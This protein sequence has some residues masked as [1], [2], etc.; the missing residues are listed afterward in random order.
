M[1]KFRV[2]IIGCGRPW[3]DAGRSGCGQAHMH[4]LGYKESKDCEIVAAADIK[5]ENLD[6]FTAEYTIPK[7]YLDYHEMFAKEKIDIVSLCVWPKLHGPMTFDSVDAGVKAIH[8]E[9]PIAP[10]FGEAKEM[11]ECCAKK[12]VQLTFNHQRRF[13]KPFRKAKELIET[14]AI[15]KLERIEMYTHNLYDWGTHWFDMMFYYNN[16]EPVEW[17]MGQVDGRGSMKIFDA[18]VEGQGLSYLKFKNAVFGFM[19]TGFGR[20]EACAHRI[21]GSDGVIEVWV[22]NGPAVRLKNMETKGEWKTFEVGLADD[23]KHDNIQTVLDLVVALKNKRE[24]MLSGRKAL[25]ATELIFATWESARRRGR[26]DLPLNITDS[27]LV[28][29]VE[30]GELVTA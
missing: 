17:V 19:S 3:G 22:K 30:E 8:C 25:A 26:V 29:M 5:K 20:S 16:E 9:K 2:G 7:G 14:G 12:G 1:G 24:P 18:L 21:C 4:I 28:T 15:G 6:K 27:P 10:T 11:V 13:G 23:V